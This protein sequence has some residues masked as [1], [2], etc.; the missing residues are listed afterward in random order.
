MQETKIL[1]RY[2]S[3]NS[4]HF[5]QAPA[6]AGRSEE[7]V[8]CVANLVQKGIVKNISFNS[9]HALH[10]KGKGYT[11]EVKYVRSGRPRR[12]RFTVYR[13][14]VIHAKSE[15]Y[16]VTDPHGEYIVV[17]IP[18]QPI[19]DI[20]TYLEAVVHERILAKKILE[21]GIKVV[22]P[23]ISSVMRHLHKLES[24]DSL[25]FCEIENAYMEILRTPGNKFVEHFKIGD[26]FVFFMQFLDEPFLGKIVRDF[27]QQDLLINIKMD[28]I[29]RD[30]NLIHK[31]DRLSFISEYKNIGTKQSVNDI[32]RALT[33]TYA[34]F[35]IGIDSLSKEFSLPFD[36]AKK[37]DLFVANVI[38][39][40]IDKSSF[41]EMKKSV[42]TNI[43][44]LISKLNKLINETTRS[45]TPFMR[46]L[47]ILD[48]EAHW[49][50]FK[51]SSQKMK[52][53]GNNLLALLAKLEETGLVLRDLKVD[54]L[55]ITDLE[56]MEL[57]IIDLETG[58]YIGSGNIEGIVPAGMPG[59]M[60]VS[61]LLFVKQL[62]NIYG[63]GKVGE[64]LH[65][66]DWY[67]TIAMMFETAIGIPLFD[68]AR[69]YILNINR[70]IDEKVANNY[71]DFI[72]NNPGVEIT[73]EMIENFF[74]LSDEKIKGHT[75]YFFALAKRDFKKKSVE[76][77]FKL[78]GILY[79]IPNALKQKISAHLDFNLKRIQD[80]YRNYKL[81]D[82]SGDSLDMSNLSIDILKK[83]LAL[84]E[85]LYNTNKA[86]PSI[87]EASKIKLAVEIDTYKDYISL[88]QKENLLNKKKYVLYQ[89]QISA[90]A[91]FPIMLDLI[92][93]VMCQDEWRKYSQKFTTSSNGEEWQNKQMTG[94]AADWKSTIVPT[95]EEL[96][97]WMKK[98]REF[99]FNKSGVRCPSSRL[100]FDARRND[101]EKTLKNS[102]LVNLKPKLSGK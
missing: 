71:C 72:R 89:E 7:V 77:S 62:Q 18:P 10:Q 88:K 56:N 4:H 42:N 84:K 70:E 58:G 73:S 15:C 67:A 51:H 99:G 102:I 6:E 16:Q 93:E 85:Q 87:N 47:E 20:A 36:H 5:S 92:I 52:M 40:S 41:A 34:T 97:N 22:V 11:Y 98:S 9:S 8:R 27:Y 96:A 21:L 33:E 80:D 14:S 31:H 38:G 74:M 64:I 101:D 82:I 39:K 90:F 50:A 91:L 29:K 66:Q 53:I 59:N 13:L 75:W 68:D 94:D 37:R 63:D 76:Y 48:Q 95:R 23:C 44:L 57:G 35:I 78:K 26:S 69:D 86:N 60:T 45:S 61:N 3:S 28:H 12:K 54:N 46:Y 30:F 43:E 25:S 83:N 17:K 1:I 2:Q 32:Y 19:T 55:F 81:T 79:C 24:V 65:I 49:L 100:A